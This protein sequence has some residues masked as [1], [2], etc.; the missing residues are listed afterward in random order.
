MRPAAVLLLL[1][2]HRFDRGFC[3]ILKRIRVPGLV[4]SGR[5]ASLHCDFDTQGE[6]LY[7][8][9]WYKG[10]Q[11]V[12][13]WLPSQLTKPITIYPR[14]GVRID[15]NKSSATSMALQAVDLSSTGRYRCE[16]STEA[17]MFSTASDFGDLL[18]VSPP[19]GPPFIQGDIRETY[20]PGDLV[21]LNC[22]SRDSK[23]AADLSWK[24]N[25]Q[26]ADSSYIIPHPVMSS[27]SGLLTSVSELFLT[28]GKRHFTQ[29]GRIRIECEARI[30]RLSQP[31]T[32]TT[33]A[34]G[35][36][37]GA[38][39]AGGTLPGATLATKPS[40]S[41]LPPEA[42]TVHMI[43]G[44]NP[45]SR[46]SNRNF[47]TTLSTGPTTTVAADL[48]SVALNI[49]SRTASQPHSESRPPTSDG[50]AN[51]ESNLNKKSLD[52]QI[53]KRPKTER[54][55]ETTTQTAT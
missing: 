8:V 47:L 10:G 38:T 16:V 31:L 52:V 34:S 17:P 4:W 41:R 24:I 48:K 3:L 22:T 11:E 25:N 20:Q 26:T 39:L 44:G 42:T 53:E 46:A 29:D 1:L 2:Q 15:Q 54:D 32:A 50:K 5:D 12:F 9:K 18:V 30:G 19:P 27:P 13:R 33:L 7:S 49:S 37:P 35:T 40:S 45:D 43:R 14:P 6:E 51:S 21:H 55:L 28:L 36:L 23:P